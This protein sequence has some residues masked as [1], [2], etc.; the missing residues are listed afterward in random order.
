MKSNNKKL[1]VKIIPIL[2]L[3]QNV[4][5]VFSY[6]VPS[7]FEGK[8]KIGILVEIFFRNQKIIG[9][10][11][12]FEKEE[13]KKNKY[14]LKNIENLLSDS[15]SL[16]G[17]QIKLAEYIADYYYTSLS[18]IMKTIIP[19]I[20]KN[21]PR[22]KIEFNPDCKISEIKKSEI[23]K[24]FKKAK[25]KNKN[26]F[27]HNLQS[28][29]HSLYYKIVKKETGAKDQTLILFP[30][31]FDIYNFAKFYFDKFEKDKVAILTSDLT[32]NQ[33]FN[34]WK[35][36]KGGSAKIIIGTR[37]AIFAPFKNLK[38]IIADNEHSSSYKQWDMNPRYHGFLMK[39]VGLTVS[40]T[41]II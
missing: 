20:T 10:I 30:E 12:G 13:V 21:K 38:L 3:P 27:I 8:I 22:K 39:Q 2:K 28:S 23:D 15:V 35:K 36:V 5:Q 11:Y 37:Q 4:V 19:I 33:Y 29:R 34:E 18:L 25:L 24:L 7:K 14:K 1:I 31:Y 17:E 26:L 40:G 9:L 32:K 41:Q 16:S 6:T